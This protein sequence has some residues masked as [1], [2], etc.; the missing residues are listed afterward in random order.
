MKSEH[1]I[2][3]IQFKCIPN[4]LSCQSTQAINN[5]HCQSI[6]LH[7]LIFTDQMDAEVSKRRVPKRMVAYKF[8]FIIIISISI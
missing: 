8:L 1:L 5:V 7:R 4:P 3:D 2:Y 6:Y